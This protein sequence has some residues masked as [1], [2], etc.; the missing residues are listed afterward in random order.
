MSLAVERIRRTCLAADEWSFIRD[1]VADLVPRLAQVSEAW[2]LDELCVRAAS[3]RDRVP[4]LMAALE[5]LAEHRGP[6]VVLLET[7]DVLRY[8]MRTPT[9]HPLPGEPNLYE[10]DLLRGYVLGLLGLYGY[11]YTTQQHGFVHHNVVPLREH[12]HNVG[13]NASSAVELSL[14]TEIASY[15]LGEGLDISPDFLTLHFFRNDPP[16]PTMVALPDWDHLPERT[17]SLLKEPWFVNQTSPAQGGM[18]HNAQRPCAVLYGQNDD[19]WIRLATYELEARLAQYTASQREAMSTF[20]AHMNAHCVEL[21]VQTGTVVLIDNRRAMH[22]RPAFGPLQMPRYDGTDRWQR[23]ITASLDR[24]RIQRYEAVP[25]V[26][27]VPG[28]IAMAQAPV[29][30][31]F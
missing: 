24:Q 16:V 2:V 9:R 27:D 21:P 7:R 6:A 5:G 15:N 25:H 23:R 12:E 8:D 4:R 17:L 31:A 30:P 10:P 3:T 19:P 28:F 29:S 11:G 1:C 18:R 26:V 13:H 20:V 22:G 14:H